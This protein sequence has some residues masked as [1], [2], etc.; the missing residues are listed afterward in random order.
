MGMNI[1]SQRLFSSQLHAIV[2]TQLQALLP[3]FQAA[4]IC[5]IKDA[6]SLECFAGHSSITRK[7]KSEKPGNPCNFPGNVQARVYPATVIRRL[8]IVRELEQGSNPLCAGRMRMSGR[9]GDVCE[10]LERMAIHAQ[11]EQKGQN[12]LTLR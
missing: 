9:M 11:N 10:E 8:K 2:K 5:T 7:P 6:Q 4:K 1:F 3:G 12:L